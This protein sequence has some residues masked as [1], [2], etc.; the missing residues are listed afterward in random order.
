M[1]GIAPEA[2]DA[3]DMIF[4]PFIHERFTVTH[5]MMLAIPLQRP[6]PAKGIGVIH[7]ALTRPLLMWQI[8]T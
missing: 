8:V 7:R 4:S 6:V 5:H 2:L 1:L 3:I